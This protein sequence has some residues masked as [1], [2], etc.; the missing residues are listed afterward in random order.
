[1][2]VLACGGTMSSFHDVH[3]GIVHPL[4]NTQEL[5]EIIPELSE[6][7]IEIDVFP[8]IIENSF[9]LTTPDWEPIYNFIKKKAKKYDGFVIIQESDTLIYGACLLGF[10]TSS[11]FKPII[12]TAHPTPLGSPYRESA[13]KNLYGAI[14]CAE[15]DIGETAIFSD[16]KLIRGVRAK[17]Q[18]IEHQHYY[19]SSFADN[20]GELHKE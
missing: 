18:N 15:E 1:M 10:L 6:Q 16:G 12:F 13:K 17:R 14:I 4:T 9:F 3:T 8:N 7:N 2:A 5:L 19:F 20:I 11:F